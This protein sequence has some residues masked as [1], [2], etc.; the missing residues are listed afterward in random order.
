MKSALTVL[1]VVGLASVA[2]ASNGGPS[3]VA[4][5]MNQVQGTRGGANVLFYVD[6]EVAPANSVYRNAL[7]TLGWSFTE[8]NS[9]AAF[10]TE[11]TGSTDYTHVISAHQNSGGTQGFEGDL[12]NYIAANPGDVI[13]VSDWR[14]LAGEP[15]YLAASGLGAGG[16]VNPAGHSP[17]GGGL[18]DGLGSPNYTN[19]GWGIYAYDTTGGVTEA[20]NGFGGAISRS[21]NVFFNGFL[22]DV[23]VGDDFG[24][25]TEYVIR[26]LGVPAPGA[27]G[28]L[29][30]AGIA[31]ARRRRA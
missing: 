1:A 12:A 24:I 11:L 16:N 18:F 21:G 31:A 27:A 3:S 6:F 9:S 14:V 13:L 29:A 4:P 7:T 22:S 15:S 10:S 28:L 25:G 5:Y 30:F 23:F 17:V 26:E 19:P 8:V 2:S 20:T